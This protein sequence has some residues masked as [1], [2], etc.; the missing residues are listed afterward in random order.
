VVYI[1]E[2]QHEIEESD[3]KHLQWIHKVW[4]DLFEWE[5]TRSDT[6]SDDQ[7]LLNTLHDTISGLE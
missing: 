2:Y 6:N 7:K 3:L 5:A 1:S 4:V